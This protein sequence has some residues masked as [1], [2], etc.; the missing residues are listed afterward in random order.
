[1]MKSRL[2][3]L[4]VGATSLTLFAIAPASADPE[5]PN[6]PASQQGQDNGAGIGCDMG[7]FHSELAK[8]GGVGKNNGPSE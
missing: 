1:M 3:S 5:V 7:K 8:E 4:L 2:I 6:P